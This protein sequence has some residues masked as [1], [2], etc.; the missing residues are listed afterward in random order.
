MPER[1]DVDT[2]RST[3]H[4]TVVFTTVPRT[5]SEVRPLLSAYDGSDE[6]GITAKYKG[7]AIVVTYSINRQLPIPADSQVWA[8][9]TDRKNFIET[10]YAARS[11]Q[12][13]NDVFS[14]DFRGARCFVKVAGIIIRGVPGD[15]L[16][17]GDTADDADEAFAKMKSDQLPE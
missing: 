13:K 4:E 5:W 14:V 15:I 17:F 16:V 12:G 7:N 9:V 11:V 1:V 3:E 8:A 10:Q 2:T 6:V